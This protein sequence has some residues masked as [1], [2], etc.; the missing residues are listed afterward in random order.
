MIGHCP[1]FR[2]GMPVQRRH[3]RR[4]ASGSICEPVL[5]RGGGERDSNPVPD[6]HNRF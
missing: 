2:R 3:L 6:V 5:K 4:L 1:A